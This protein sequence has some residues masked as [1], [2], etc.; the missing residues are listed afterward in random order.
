MVSGAIRSPSQA[1]APSSWYPAPTV[2]RPS[3]S[4]MPRTSPPQPITSSLSHESPK[5]A[6]ASRSKANRWKSDR[7]REL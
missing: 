7:V 6:G 4:A 2:S 3:L 5:P 1:K